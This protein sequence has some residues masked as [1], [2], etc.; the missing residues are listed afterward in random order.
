MSS[1]VHQVNPHM[2]SSHAASAIANIGH[3]QIHPLM[4]FRFSS[5]FVNFMGPTVLDA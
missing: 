3:S 5:G 4:R 1:A 2:T